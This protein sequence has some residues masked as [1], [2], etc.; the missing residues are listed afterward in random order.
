MAN[1]KIGDYIYLMRKSAGLS[2]EELAFR[3]GVATETISRLEN[4][5]HKITTNVYKKLMFV[6]DNFP[7]R[8]YGIC[9]IKDVEIIE[10]KQMEE[11]AEV[12]FEYEKAQE[13]L[14]FIKQKA[15]DTEENQQYILRAEAML[16]YYTGK[17]NIEQ[18]LEKLKY[19]LKF[20]IGNYE[21]IISSAENYP[22]TEQE[23]CILLNIADSYGI[24]NE[25]E[26]DEKIKRKLLNGIDMGYIGGRGI[27]NL[28]LTIKRNLAYSMLLQ[29]RY[30]EA[31]EILTS[32]LKDAKNERNG[33]IISVVL[34][35]MAWS[36]KKINTV[37]ERIVYEDKEIKEILRKAYYVAAAR[38]DNYVRDI[39]KNVFMKEYNIDIETNVL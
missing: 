12:K 7:Q 5:R 2:Q 32:V 17:L 11:D 34:S 28:Y 39:V 18:M 19:A 13:Y 25:Y 14:E 8:F 3:A 16:E 30:E 33:I 1:Y 38:N 29:K 24:I 10:M 20:T 6:L 35:D 23:I 37:K 36:M 4:G 27:Q 26:M 22:F 15:D 9:T 21:Q 31:M